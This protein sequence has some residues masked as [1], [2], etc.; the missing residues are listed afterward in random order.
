MIQHAFVLNLIGISTL[1]PTQAS[2]DISNAPRITTCEGFPREVLEILRTARY[3][4]GKS[5]VRNKMKVQWDFVTAKIH[6][7]VTIIQCGGGGGGGGEIK[8]ST[9]SPFWAIA[10]RINA[11]QAQERQIDLII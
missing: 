3:S 6:V 1:L 9:S 5:D 11:D 10:S 8:Y 7:R 4:I 2:N